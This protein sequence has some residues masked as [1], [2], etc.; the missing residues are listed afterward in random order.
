M[1]SGRITTQM[2]TASVLSSINNV[3]DQLATTQQQLSTGLSINQP[4]DNPYGASLAVQLKNDLQG[5]SNYN[6]N[7]TD[8]T[9][10]AS[11]ADTSLQNITSMLQRAQ[12]LTVQSS[13]GVESSTDLSATADEI[14]QLADAIKQ[15]ANTQ[16]NGQYIFSGTASTTQPYSDSTGDTFQGN[17]AAVSRQIG[18]GSTLQVNVDVSSV[19]GSGTSANDGKLLDT[20][21][22]ISADLRSGNSA[23]ITDLSTN[24]ITNLQNSLNSLTQVQANV[25]ATQNRLTLAGDRIQGL[26]NNDTAALSNDEDINMAQAMTTFSNQQAAFTAALK[27][28]ANIVQS[29]LM[30][31]LSS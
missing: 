1:I 9:A 27:A 21:R 13:N 22:S 15:E 3:Q 25:G 29:S 10:W 24:Q 30:D 14:D 18:P 11:A 23:G 12:E 6:S 4:S 5:L 17:T 19:L 7:I 16:Y 31:F 26:Q 2:T 8:G 28:G 20:L